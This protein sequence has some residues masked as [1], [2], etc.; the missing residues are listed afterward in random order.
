MANALA[1]GS[2]ANLTTMADVLQ[3]AVGSL[4]LDPNLIVAGA[5]TPVPLVG[6]AENAAGDGFR[7]STTGGRPTAGTLFYC[8]G[9]L[10]PGDGDGCTY[11]GGTGGTIGLTFTLQAAMGVEV[12]YAVGEL[13]PGDS[14]IVVFNAIV[15]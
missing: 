3:G 12:G 4:A 1:A 13:A 9:D 10:P 5:T 2:S 15:Q 6:D 11:S 14:V 8:T 7:V